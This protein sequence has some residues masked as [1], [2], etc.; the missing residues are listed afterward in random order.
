MSLAEIMS[1]AGLSR[2][3]EVALVLFF[4]AF[5]LIVWR[6][7]RPSRRQEL[8]RHKALPLEPDAD[9]STRHGSH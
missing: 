1:S 9:P 6:V 8:E 4:A 3:A 5:L 7:F 2:Y